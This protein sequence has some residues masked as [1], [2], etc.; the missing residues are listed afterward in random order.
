MTKLTEHFT[1]EEMIKSSTAIRKGINNQPTDDIR[2]NL[3]LLCEHVL[4][5]VRA[6]FGK[7]VSITSGYRSVKLNKAIGGSGTSQHREGKAADFTVDGISNKV[8]CEWIK[9]NL[10]FDQLIYEFGESGWVHCS[11]D[12][13]PRQNVIS[14]QKKSGKTVYVGGIK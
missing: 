3:K 10:V 14:A 11:Y 8:V 13:T 6:A 4:E 7:S 2:N 9:D 12:N 5:P 1:L